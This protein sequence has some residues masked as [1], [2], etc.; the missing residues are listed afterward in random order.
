VIRN[1]WLLWPYIF[2]MLIGAILACGPASGQ[3]FT[4]TPT[5]TPRRV[6]ILPQAPIATPTEPLLL[7][8]AP[9]SEALPVDTPTPLP[10]TATSVPE[11]PPTDTPTPEPPPPTDTP[12]PPPPTNTP[13]PPPPTNTPAPPPPTQPPANEGPKASLEFK[14]SNDVEPGDDIKFDIVVYDPDG[15]KTFTWG[16]FTLNNTPLPIGGDK[17]CGGATECRHEVETEAPP[18]RDTYK[19]GVDAV[20]NAGKSSRGFVGEIYVN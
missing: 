11:L 3:Q 7:T 19:V 5:K 8:T 18:I 13:A 20:D 2:I 6:K 4:P 15:V 10:P 17:D 12:I 9:T 1:S 16:V 14:S